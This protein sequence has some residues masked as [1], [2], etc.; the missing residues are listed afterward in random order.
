MG[1]F[2]VDLERFVRR[3]SVNKDRV[4]KKVVIDLSTAMIKRTPVGDP[5]TWKHPAPAGYAGGRA[6]GSWTY[7]FEAEPRGA[8]EVDGSGQKSMDRIT[9]GLDAH[10]GVGI[11]YIINSVPYM[12]R[13]EYEGWSTQAPAGM[14]RIT[15]AEFQS[16]VDAAIAD[17]RRNRSR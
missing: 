10:P 2:V 16:F 7:G 3:F 11:H 14:V 17:V 5:L 12:R 6:R 15:V 4:I 1:Q 9:A 13:L 8:D